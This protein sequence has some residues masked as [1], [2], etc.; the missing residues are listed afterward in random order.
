MGDLATLVDG[1]SVGRQDNV[2]IEHQPADALLTDLRRPV[3]R[4]PDHVAVALDDGA[5]TPSDSPKRACSR[6]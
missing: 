1:R 5:G 4:K 2:A 3:R 6:M